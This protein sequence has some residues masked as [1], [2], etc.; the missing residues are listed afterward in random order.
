MSATSFS[1]SISSVTWEGNSI[2]A[3]SILASRNKQMCVVY[4]VEAEMDVV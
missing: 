3:S 2:Q 4:K 1:I